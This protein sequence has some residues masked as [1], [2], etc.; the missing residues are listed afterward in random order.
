VSSQVFVRV[1][2]EAFLEGFG[3]LRFVFPAETGITDYFQAPTNPRIGS[4]AR[5]RAKEVSCYAISI[6]NEGGRI[7]PGK[8]PSAYEVLFRKKG[9]R[10]GGLT[11]QSRSEERL[12]PG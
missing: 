9:K 12:R 2:D 11:R 7:Y 5:R 3:L 10:L 8:F 6:R 1:L 4:P